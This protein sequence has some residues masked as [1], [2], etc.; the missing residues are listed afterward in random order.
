VGDCCIAQGAQAGT[1]VRWEGVR[2]GR[3]VH[4]G[5]DTC[6]LWLVPIVVW[7]RPPQHCKAIIPQLKINLKECNFPPQMGS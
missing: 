3:V 4:E 1:L 5:G 6:I 7:Q 2:A